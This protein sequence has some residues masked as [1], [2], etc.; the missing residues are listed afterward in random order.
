MSSFAL[1]SLGSELNG[2]ITVQPKDIERSIGMPICRICYDSEP[3]NL[4]E[5]CNCKGSMGQIHKNCL[6]H[7]LSERT[8][9]KCELCAFEYN[10]EMVPKYK[11]LKSIYVWTKEELIRNFSTDIIGIIYGM[12]ILIGAGFF[13]FPRMYSLEKVNKIKGILLSFL[14][15]MFIVNSIV[16]IITMIYLV[17]KAY[18]NWTIWKTLQTNVSLIFK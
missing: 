15:L 7:W 8:S 13:I 6:E 1:K 9:K 4:I 11:L 5:P 10:V 18:K 14:I 17:M 3:D 16:I 2:I 12:V